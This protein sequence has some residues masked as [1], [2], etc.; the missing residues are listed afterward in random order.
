MA[1]GDWISKPRPQLSYS[2]SLMRENL[3]VLRK[4]DGIFMYQLRA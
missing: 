2:I 4:S 3:A 1:D